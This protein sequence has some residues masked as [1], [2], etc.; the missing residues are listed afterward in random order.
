[1]AIFNS[2]VSHYQRVIRELMSGTS[3]FSTA[4]SP[5]IKPTGWGSQSSELAFSWFIFVAEFYG[6]W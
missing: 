6:L 3:T 1:M 2:Y 5:P 4:L